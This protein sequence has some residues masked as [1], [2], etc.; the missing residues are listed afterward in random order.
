[1][2]SIELHPLMRRNAQITDG[3]PYCPNMFR[4]IS[5]TL[6]ASLSIAAVPGDGINL[7]QALVIERGSEQ[8]EII[9]LISQIP[10]DIFTAL[11]EI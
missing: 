6:V 3:T 5:S 8:N 11:H 2:A 7:G 9:G 1:M 10:P 4:I